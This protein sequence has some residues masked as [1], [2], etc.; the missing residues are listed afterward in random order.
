MAQGV[1]TQSWEN[2]AKWPDTCPYGE[3]EPMRTIAQFQKAGGDTI[4]ISQ[5]EASYEFCG[6]CGEYETKG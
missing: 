1:Q 2:C 3:D 5:L 6:K 4:D